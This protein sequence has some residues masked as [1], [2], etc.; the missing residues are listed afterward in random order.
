MWIDDYEG[1]KAELLDATHQL[2]TEHPKVK[3]IV[4]ECTNMPPFS[5]EVEK[6]TGLRVYDIL[7]LGK[8][9]Y[10]GAVPK[11]YRSIQG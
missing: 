4:L 6:A 2:V 5:H 1:M 7:T 10:S 9:L 11:D 8:W 3:V